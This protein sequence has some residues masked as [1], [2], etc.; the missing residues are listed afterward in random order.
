MMAPYQQRVLDEQRELQGR[1]ERLHAFI[2]S[3]NFESVVPDKIDRLL[4][5]AQAS[6]MTAYGLVLQLRIDRFTTT[7][8]A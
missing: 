6:A 4:L 5:T 8:G 7:T 1:I 3:P 2:D